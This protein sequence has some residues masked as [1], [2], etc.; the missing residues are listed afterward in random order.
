MLFDG[1]PQWAGILGHSLPDTYVASDVERVEV[2]RGPGALLYGSNAM[3]GVV[4]I[5]TASIISRD[6]VHKPVS[7]TARI[8]PR[9]I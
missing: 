7:C 4:N 5:I 3:G 9:S 2:I 1:Q 6:D 8:T